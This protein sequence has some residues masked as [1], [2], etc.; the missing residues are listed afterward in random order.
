MP[1]VAA[2]TKAGS[3]HSREEMLTGAGARLT[4]IGEKSGDNVGTMPFPV[5]TTANKP[6]TTAAGAT[7]AARACPLQGVA[8]AAAQA[9]VG[10]GAA[11]EAEAAE[12]EADAA[13]H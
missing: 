3:P 11:A 7:R 2:V 4:E 13:K 8:A 6:E 9:A 12:A 5:L 10:A 1:I